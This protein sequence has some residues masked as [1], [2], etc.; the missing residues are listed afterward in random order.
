MAVVATLAMS[1]TPWH[2]GEPTMVGES[3]EDAWDAR[4][5]GD[6][7]RPTVEL[8]ELTSSSASTDEAAKKPPS[9]EVAP[10]M[11]AMGVRPWR[12]RFELSESSRTAIW[13]V[14]LAEAAGAGAAPHAEVGGAGCSGTERTFCVAGWVAAQDVWL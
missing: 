7:V 4:N 3:S 1:A 5:G 13:M 10:A 2:V 8:A 9:G 11:L 6:G 12:E 14:E